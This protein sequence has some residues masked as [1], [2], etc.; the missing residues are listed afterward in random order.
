MAVFTIPIIYFLI[1]FDQDGFSSTQNL[2]VRSSLSNFLQFEVD[3]GTDEATIELQSKEYQDKSTNYFYIFQGLDLGYSFILWISILIL[4]IIMVRKRKQILKKCLTVQKYSLLVKM[5]PKGTTTNELKE[6]FGQ[7]AKLVDVNAIFDFKGSL[8]DLKNL[9]KMII[10]RRKYI[11]NLNYP[12]KK[13]DKRET[14]ILKKKIIKIDKKIDKEI[15]SIH[16]NLN[17][18]P[19]EKIDLENF[20]NLK[21][22]EAYITFEDFNQMQTMYKNFRKEYKKGCCDKTPDDKRYYLKGSKIQLKSPDIPSNINWENIGY[23]GVKRFFRVFITIIFI[24]IL[25][26]LSTV[27]VLSLTSFRE[28]SK[29]NQQDAK[30]ECVEKMSLGS[31]ELIENKTE[32]ITYC[33]C[34][35]QNQL[36][37]L[38][39]S[40]INQYCLGFLTEQSLIYAKQIGAAI[41]ISVVDLLFAFLIVV[42][43][44]FVSLFTFKI[45]NE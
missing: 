15:K 10:K 27:L 13:L 2:F 17:I 1:S 35:H 31:F 32:E 22:I 25:L 5:L 20:S 11:K 4:K 40:S 8:G 6:F 21:I 7:F 16:Q 41:L 26:V 30:N 34:V 42:V 44:R 9:A 36:E 18:K 3:E 12:E 14:I 28:S 19:N 24:A 29:L 33:F 39:N 43:I 38:N 23:S 45:I 37:L